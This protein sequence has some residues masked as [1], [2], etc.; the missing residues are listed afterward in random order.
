MGND[1]LKNF[2]LVSRLV[3]DAQKI[4]PNEMENLFTI[5][6]M[7]EKISNQDEIVERQTPQNAKDCSINR[8]CMV[9]KSGFSNMRLDERLCDMQPMYR[10]DC[11][12]YSE[13]HDMGATVPQC[14]KAPMGV[15]PCI[16]GC[17]EFISRDDVRKMVAEYQKKEGNK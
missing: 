13:W 9:E 12:W 3:H 11:Y 4:S 8:N 15:C 14:G 17:M 6:D 16:D 10:N 7:K 5:A 1:S 2:A